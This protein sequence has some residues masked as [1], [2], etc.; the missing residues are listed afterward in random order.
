MPSAKILAGAVNSERRRGFNF[1]L[2]SYNKKFEQSS[3]DARKPIGFPV[4]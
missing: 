4:Q 3:R 1:Y 2:T